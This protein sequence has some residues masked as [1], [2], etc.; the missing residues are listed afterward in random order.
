MRLTTERTIIHSLI[1]NPEFF[2]K[3]GMH[4]KKEHFGEKDTRLIAEVIDEYVAQYNEIPSATEIET[5][6]STLNLD[7]DMHQDITSILH[8]KPEDEINFDWLMS[9]AEDHCRRKATH[10]ALVRSLD[11]I[12]GKDKKLGIESIGEMMERA[13]HFKFEN[14]IGLNFYDDVERKLQSYSETAMK[15]PFKLAMLNKITGGGFEKRTVNCVAAPTGFGKSIW[16]GDEAVFQSKQG[17]NVVYITFEMSDDRIAKRMDATANEISLDDIRKKNDEALLEMFNKVRNKKHGYLILKEF[18]P[19]EV[20]ASKVRLY[21]REVEMLMGEKVDVVCLDYLNLMHSA[22]FGSS[23]GTYMMLKGIC[24]ELVALAKKMDIA[25]LTATQFN[26]GGQKNSSPEIKDI[27]ESQAIA[28]TVDFLLALFDTDELEK[29]GRAVA[30]QLKNRYGDK[31]LYKA[32]LIGIERA[33]MGFYD[34]SE[35]ESDKL[36]DNV[37]TPANIN[38]NDKPDFTKNKQGQMKFN[39]F[40]FETFN[41]S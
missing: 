14:D 30:K 41:M 37:E 5:E 16:L 31:N 10:N 12:E 24:E 20:T 34:V 15:I 17:L 36:I 22:R 19:G 38:I 18:G 4:I 35:K 3:A 26:R 39:N 2:S 29:A 27:S 13:T 32:F 25:I 1:N 21:L 23:G 33:K 7:V 6:L 9:V 28:N 8:Y 11:I 40:D